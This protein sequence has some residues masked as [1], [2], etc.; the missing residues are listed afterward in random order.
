MI[1]GKKK[2]FIL[3]LHIT[4]KACEEQNPKWFYFFIFPVHGIIGSDQ[5][6]RVLIKDQS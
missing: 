5:L 4:V 2:K 6:R 3:R 1:V